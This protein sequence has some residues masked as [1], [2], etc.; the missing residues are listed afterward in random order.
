MDP[1]EK[2][3][4]DQSYVLEITYIPQLAKGEQASFQFAL[5]SNFLI[6]DLEY[7]LDRISAKMMAFVDFFI[8]TLLF[9]P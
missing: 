2:N 7:N 5:R 8:S 1:L 6:T 9:Y 4:P 3:M